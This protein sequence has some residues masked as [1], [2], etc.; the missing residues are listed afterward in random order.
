MI[1]WR[2]SVHKFL[3]LFLFVTS[4]VWAAEFYQCKD[5]KG[6]P[7]FSQTPCAVDAKKQYVNEPGLKS[8]AQLKRLAASKRADDIRRKLI[9]EQ[10]RTIMAMREYRDNELNASTDSGEQAAINQR[11]EEKISAARAKVKQLEQELSSLDF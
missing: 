9:P 6:R 8:E 5:A 3:V 7:I 2:R 11:Y 10:Y 4:Q 1:A